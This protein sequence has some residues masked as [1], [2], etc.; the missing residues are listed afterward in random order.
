[1]AGFSFSAGDD[2]FDLGAEDGLDFGAEIEDNLLGDPDDVQPDLTPELPQQASSP[3]FTV[4]APLRQPDDNE[5]L[6]SVE[7]TL[8]DLL[9]QGRRQDVLALTGEAPELAQRI[10]EEVAAEFGPQYTK[11][12]A[13]NPAIRWYA[14]FSKMLGPDAFGL[15]DDRLILKIGQAEFKRLVV[16][17]LGDFDPKLADTSPIVGVVI[18]LVE[19]INGQAQ[20]I[21]LEEATRTKKRASHDRHAFDPGTMEFDTEEAPADPDVHSADMGIFDDMFGV[22]EA[23]ESAARIASLKLSLLDLPTK[24]VAE[25]I[26]TENL[27]EAAADDLLAEQGFDKAKR[28]EIATIVKYAK[29]NRNLRARGRTAGAYGGDVELPFNFGD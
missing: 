25:Y 13:I 26:D 12:V 24:A 5:L 18:G 22:P 14:K 4:A 21:G 2:E 17:F 23:D 20:T 10:D 1:M 16:P 27:T 28:N 11:A 29:L 6:F 9:G 15:A 8:L 7:D 3:D 19:K